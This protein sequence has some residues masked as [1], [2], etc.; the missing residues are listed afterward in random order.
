MGIFDMI[1][2]GA[3]K[4]SKAIQD[5]VDSKIKSMSNQELLERKEKWESEGK[6]T[7]LLDKEIEDRKSKHR[8]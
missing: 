8:M 3:S 2:K 7:T 6:D 1:A 5:G 4:V